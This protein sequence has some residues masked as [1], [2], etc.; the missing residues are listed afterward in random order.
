[1]SEHCLICDQVLN[2]SLTWTTLLFP[3]E[4]SPLCEKCEEKFQ[5]IQGD[6][7]EVCGR[8]M[9][10]VEEQ[11]RQGERCLDCV[12]WEEN[13]DWGRIFRQNR[14]LYV[15]N[16]WMKE[17]IALY[18]FRGDYQ[19]ADI[20]RR[21]WQKAYRIYYPQYEVIVPIP[22]SEERLYE[23]GFNQ[24]AVLAGLLQKPVQ[25][26]MARHHH[27]KQSKK[28][29]KERLKK[30]QVFFLKEDADLHGKK[31]LLIDDIYTT[32]TTLHHAA[33]VLKEAGAEVVSSLT[34]A[35]G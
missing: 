9:E 3:Q 19:L 28:T 29:K 31:V 30:E 8:E 10:G 2:E 20:F 14:S 13:S 1:M 18:K 21:K 25:D 15:Y 32:G 16:D 12:K 24:S 22:L 7:C 27:E 6:I 17:V 35:R 23:R 33:K 11:Y 34:L 5:W 4:K 26:L